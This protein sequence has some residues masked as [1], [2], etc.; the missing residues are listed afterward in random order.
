MSTR[1]KIILAVILVMV[2]VAGRILPHVWNFAPIIAI[3]LFAGV[4]LGKRYALILPLAAM[5]V[6]DIFLGFYDFKL[7]F[8]V[9]GS[10]ALAGMIGYFIRNCKNVFTIS[11]A[12]ISA[13]TFFYVITNWAVWQF[14]P[15]YEKTIEGL[16]MSYTLALP[17]FR[18]ALV[19]DL[20]YTFVF[21]GA[22][23][24]V[25]YL[26]HQR[27]PQLSKTERPA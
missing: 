20:F 15:F 14:S 26:V 19:G 13:S 10:F 24:A 23:E 21:F 18:G 16:M 27:K 25:L 7:M 3:G 5:L 6:S 9:Y 12:S 1:V 11:S 17:F 22:Y 8:F 2:G 4:Y